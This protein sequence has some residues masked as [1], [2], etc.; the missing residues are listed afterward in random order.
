MKYSFILI[1]LVSFILIDCTSKNTAVETSLSEPVVEIES[2]FQSIIDSM[3]RKVPNT[4]GIVMHVES[5][6]LKISWNGATGW[7]DF[8]SQRELFASDPVLIASITKTYL[9][10]AILRLVENG[11]L[12]LNQ[13]IYELLGAERINQLVNV[14]YDV[15]GI[16]VAHLNSQTSGIYDFVNTK[17]YQSRTAN[18][19]DY[20]WSREDQIELALTVEPLFRQEERFSYSETNNLLLTEILEKKTGKPF[21]TAMRELLAYDELGLENTWFNWLEKVPT[22]VSPL[23]HQFASEYNVDSYSLHPSFDV[24]GGGGIAATAEDVAKFTQFLF[25]GRLF[26]NK[27]TKDLLFKT[28]L[29][30]DGINNAYYMAISE[31]KLGRHI[32][33]GHGG[34]WGTTTQYFP[35]LNASVSIFFM[36]R[37]E[38]PEYMVILEQVAIILEQEKKNAKTESI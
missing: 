11:D 29:T 32:A 10:A 26:K 12:Q 28:V 17:L 8:G 36:E 27:G 21:Y 33:Y 35:A 38:W 3:Y 30:T 13:S 22:G 20:L 16:T 25:T 7:A 24:Y 15:K 34:F 23:V 31:T 18:S 9:S 14:G 37:D 6:D 1:F 5:P 19:P 4:K 2:K